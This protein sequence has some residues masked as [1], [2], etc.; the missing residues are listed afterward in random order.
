M[1]FVDVIEALNKQ[2]VNILR[3]SDPGIDDDL[4]LATNSEVVVECEDPAKWDYLVRK[5]SC[6]GIPVRE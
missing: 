6:Q 1:P 5:V 4:L 2:G 3:Y